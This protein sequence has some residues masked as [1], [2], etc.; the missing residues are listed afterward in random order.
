M[1]V[2]LVVPN[3]AAFP[4]SPPA[5]P[6]PRHSHPGEEVGYLIQGDIVM[7]FDDRPALTVH[8]GEP[9]LI[10]PGAIHNARNIGT[11][12]PRMLS[13]YFVDDSRPLVTIY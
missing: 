3:T 8:S 12:E 9:F 2:L 5:F 11:V 6:C 10:P 1:N 7:E 4:P 13:S